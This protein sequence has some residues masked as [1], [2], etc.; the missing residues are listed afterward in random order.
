MQKGH[1]QIGDGV[2]YC[3]L[4]PIKYKGMVKLVITL[5]KKCIKTRTTKAASLTKL[6]TLSNKG[7]LTWARS[8]PSA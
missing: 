7:C 1:R 6:I 4:L 3:T 5:N 8:Y 2:N